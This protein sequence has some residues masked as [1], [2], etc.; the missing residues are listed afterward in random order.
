MGEGTLSK[1][2][3]TDLKALASQTSEAEKFA[4]KTPRLYDDDQ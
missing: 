3:A 4:T 2:K 1:S